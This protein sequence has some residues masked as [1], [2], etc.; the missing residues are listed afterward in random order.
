MDILVTAAT[1]ME[2]KD[3]LLDGI[4]KI[5]TS[6]KLEIQI[7]G[8][9][10][11][12]TLYELTRTLSTTK[13]DLVIQAGIA[14]TF[15]K[16]L[17]LGTVAIIERDAFGELGI[18]EGKTFQTLFESGLM[19]GNMPPYSDGWLVNSHLAK[20]EFKQVSGV[21]VNTIGDSKKHIK[22]LKQKFKPSVETMEG[23]AFHYVCLQTQ[24]SFIQLRSVSNEVGERDKNKWDMKYALINLNKELLNVIQGSKSIIL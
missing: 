19:D 7:T 24:H 16:K 5:D 23:A 10:I 14:G 11:P 12:S 18:V 13:Y 6:I 17:P 20:G 9:G 22:R 2:I 4:S 21:T 3:F 8:I 1:E 15:S